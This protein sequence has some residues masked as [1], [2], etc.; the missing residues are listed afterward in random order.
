MLNVTVGSVVDATTAPASR[1]TSAQ[2]V[3]ASA[4]N[5]ASKRSIWPTNGAPALSRRYHGTL[6]GARPG[7]SE[8]V[9]RG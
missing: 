4:G 9:A 7:S 2:I 5:L 3:V 6:T 8:M 1:S